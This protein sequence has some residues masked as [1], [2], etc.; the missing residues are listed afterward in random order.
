VSI[1]VK[2]LV[3]KNATLLDQQF[4]NKHI[5]L[6]VE[7]NPAHYVFADYNMIDTVLRNLLSN[8]I[9][10][11]EY[12]GK[13]TVTSTAHDD[14]IVLNIADT[15]VGMSADQVKRIF[16]LDKANISTGTAGERGTGLGLVIC[17]EFIEANKGK[18]NV[19]S[20][21]AQGTTF[22]IALPKS[23]SSIKTRTKILYDIPRDTPP[24]SFWEA[25]P[26]E[27]LMKIK[28]KKI[29]IVDD[30]R[31]LRS[32][33]KL[34]LSE[35][36]EIFEAENGQEGMK[37]ALEIQPT[38]IISDVIMPHVNGIQF[39]KE[40][41]TTTATSHLPVILLTSVAEEH[42][43]LEGYEA[44]ADAY[45]NKPVRKEIL[46]QVILNLIQSQEKVRDRMRE[47]I[48][49]NNTIHP[50]D[51]AVN[52]RDEEFLNR[53]IDFINKNISDPAL[54]ARHISEE[55]G[56][57][58]SVLYSKIKTLTGQSVHEFIKSIRLKQSLKLLLEGRH[59]ISQIALEVGFNSHSYF[60][61]CFVK[62]YGVGPKEY[63]AKRKNMRIG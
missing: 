62:Q 9:K 15:G 2:E 40:I 7:V 22:H 34:L 45:L 50:E 17:H 39:C 48:L 37:H 24:L 20:Q 16:D 5:V 63:L 38:A 61:K 8:S 18:I 11:T 54:D 26:M 49:G 43:Q 23:V 33:L 55:F 47:S 10:F 51:F 19:Q 57:S 52:K 28:G 35:T 53:L 21:P 46:I 12:N 41:K 36:F 59:T 14:D 13:V 60:D 1:N 25:F 29:L 32:Y 4:R 56:I 6:N 27:K 42:G 44:G 30:N 3:Q 31:E 58:R